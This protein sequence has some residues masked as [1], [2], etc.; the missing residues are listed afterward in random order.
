M[1][2]KRKAKIIY[3]DSVDSTNTYLKNMALNGAENGTAVIA[4][5]QTAGRGRTGNSFV[6]DEGGLYLSVLIDT[7]CLEIP[8]TTALTSCTAV[9]VAHALKDAVGI[10]PGIK[11]VND[12]ILNEKK[13]GGILVEAGRIAD[14]RIPYVVAGIGINVN[15]GRFPET[16]AGMAA[17]IRRETGEKYPVDAVSGAI[18]AR[19]DELITNISSNNLGGYLKEYRELCVT[20]G[21]TVVFERNGQIITAEAK[22][23]TEDYGLLVTYR[24]GTEEILRCGD[25][26]VRGLEG[27]V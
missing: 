11:W 23:I 25:V 4:L 8:E 27:Y 1:E 13:L 6:S 24:D 18:I 15:Q 2:S 14:G 17:S 12:M 20:V 7:H 5:K 3:L 26:H 9:A 10:T 22:K 16:I 21:R 19:M